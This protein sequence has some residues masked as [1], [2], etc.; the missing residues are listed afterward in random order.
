MTRKK[1]GSGEE[2][3][4]IAVA[5]CDDPLSVTEMVLARRQTKSALH[6]AAHHESGQGM[7]HLWSRADATGGDGGESNPRH[8]YSVSDATSSGVPVCLSPQTL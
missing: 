3:P 5:K 2:R 6:P 4:A 1:R 7:E 8:A